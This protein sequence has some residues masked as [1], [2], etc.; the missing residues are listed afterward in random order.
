M[1]SHRTIFAG[2][3]FT[4]AACATATTPEQRAQ[5]KAAEVFAAEID[6]SSAGAQLKAMKLADGK[7]LE[8]M[9]R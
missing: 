3:I 9:L 7:S 1:L 8:K 2:M 6:V 4:L 5:E